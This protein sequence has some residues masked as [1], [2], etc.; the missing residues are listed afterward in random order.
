MG[1]IPPRLV[2]YPKDIENIT[3]RRPR[4]C[5]AILSKIRIFYRKR[6]GEMVTIKEFCAFMHL[7]EDEVRNFL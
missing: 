5:R 6:P 1:P 2:I 7:S 3:G 4:T